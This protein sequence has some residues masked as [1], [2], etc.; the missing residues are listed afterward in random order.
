[1]RARLLTTIPDS[2]SQKFILLGSLSRSDAS[3]IGARHAMVF[4]DFSTLG[5]KKCNKDT[6]MEKWYARTSKSKECLMGHKVRT[7]GAHSGVF[8]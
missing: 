3:T 2:T 5:K 8:V 4:L 7:F 6:D 1:M